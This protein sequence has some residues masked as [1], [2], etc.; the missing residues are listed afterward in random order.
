[1]KK[2]TQVLNSPLRIGVFAVCTIAIICVIALASIHVRASVNSNKSIGLNKG[3]EV[4]L[5]DAGFT[6][7]EVTGLTAHYDSDKGVASYDIDFSANGYEYDYTIKASDGSIIEANR[8]KIDEPDINYNQ[9]DNNGDETT[10]PPEKISSESDN[11]S[12][13]TSANNENN[14]T[15]NNNNTNDTTSNSSPSNNQSS[16]SSSSKYIGVDEAKSIAL[17]D[18]GL[19]SSS[20]RFTKAKLD[21]EDGII[22]YDVEFYTNGTEYEYE[23]NATSGKIISKDIDWDDDDHWDDWD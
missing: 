13:N 14:T 2:I 18:A 17:K 21:R 23:I 8:E 1:M 12:G 7:D 4:A 19:S 16:S 15:S 6:A 5:H 10:E 3:V 20:V 22:I 11:T 9:N